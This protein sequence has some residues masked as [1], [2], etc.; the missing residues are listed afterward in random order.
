MQYHRKVLKVT[1]RQISSVD[2]L[3]IMGRARQ[4]KTMA[5]IVN[6]NRFRKAKKRLAD[7]R[8]ADVNRVKFGRGKTEK[9]NDRRQAEKQRQEIDDK[10]RDE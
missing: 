1:S 5:E 3:P 9:L 10:K 7:E 8:Q 4:G 6:L 2:L